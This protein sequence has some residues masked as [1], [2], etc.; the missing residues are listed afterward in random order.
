M[1][2]SV[3]YILKGCMGAIVV[4][5]IAVLSKSRYIYLAGLAPLF[6][7][8]AMFAHVFAYRHDGV[9]AVK[10]VVIFGMLS[11]IPY[12]GYLLTMLVIT[13]RTSISVAI[14]ASVLVWCVLAVALIY[15]WNELG[16][17]TTLV[18]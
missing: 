15:A 7:T 14:A 5:F 12:I 1:G 18:G 2:V 13:E 11:I 4:M 3:E 6:P 16:I 8:F 9:V 17:R 10:E